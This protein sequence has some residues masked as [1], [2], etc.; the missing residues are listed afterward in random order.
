MAR[1][2]VQK[3]GKTGGTPTRTAANGGG[4]SFPIS[5]AQQKFDFANSSGAPITVTFHA[6]IRCNQGF[7]VAAA[8]FPKN[9]ISYEASNTNQHYNHREKLV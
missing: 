1:K 7:Y 5:S 4:D 3:F 8:P 2:T 9:D 6:A